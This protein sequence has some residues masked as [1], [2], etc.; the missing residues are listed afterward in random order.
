MKCHSGLDKEGG[1][2]WDGCVNDAVHF[3]KFNSNRAGRPE[4]FTPANLCESCHKIFCS[5]KHVDG[6]VTRT[7]F[8]KGLTNRFIPIS[9]DEAEELDAEVE[10]Q[11]IMES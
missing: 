2:T 10:I 5:S 7:G 8:G 1:L 9:L 4:H 3:Y 6:R 11:G